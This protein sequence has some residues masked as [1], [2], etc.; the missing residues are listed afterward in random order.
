MQQDEPSCQRRTVA[1]KLLPF[2]D[3]FSRINLVLKRSNHT[4]DFKE[5]QFLVTSAIRTVHGDIANQVDII[6]FKTIDPH[7]YSAIIRFKTV[8]S[9]RIVTSLLLYGTWKD[10]DCRFDIIK[11]AST[12]C[13]LSI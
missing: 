5:F 11:V 8:H 2:Q 4:I 1:A 9:T 6:H 7:N 12:L 13:S 3:S 10:T